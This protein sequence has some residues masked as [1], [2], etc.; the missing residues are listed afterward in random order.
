ML[1]F[2]F[3]KHTKEVPK[4]GYDLQ[5]GQIVAMEKYIGNIGNTNPKTYCRCSDL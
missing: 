4:R 5:I 3:S 2:R 1:N